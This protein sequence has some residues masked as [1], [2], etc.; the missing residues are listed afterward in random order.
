V[1]KF[2][3]RTR[4]L[5]VPSLIVRSVNGGKFHTTRLVFL[6][7]FSLITQ[8]PTLLLA[9][10]LYITANTS[11]FN[12]TQTTFKLTLVRLRN[13]LISL[14]LISHC[15]FRQSKTQLHTNVNRL[16]SFS[17]PNNKATNN[18]PTLF[19]TLFP[20]EKETFYHRR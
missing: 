18:K 5:P 19:P 6:L 2:Y 16:P 9:L 10:S 13:G 14:A 8:L 15:L 4:L 17:T 7:L 1:T 20:P 12:K 3:I 11:L